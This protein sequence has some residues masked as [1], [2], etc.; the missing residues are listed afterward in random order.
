MESERDIELPSNMGLDALSSLLIAIVNSSDDAIISKTLDGIV[1]S[2]NPAAEAMFGY[3]AAEVVGQSIRIIIPSD[4]QEEEDFVL[5]KIRCGERVDHFETIRQTKDGQLLNISLTVS[6]VRNASGT[7]VGVSKI[8]RDITIRK[9]M[10]REREE[11]LARERQIRQQLADALAARDEFIAVAAHELRNPL[12][13]LNLSLQI[14]ERLARDPSAGDKIQRFILKCQNQLKQMASLTD[15]LL[16]VTK[17][18]TGT[19]EL[20]REPV[21]LGGL[22]REVA[23]RFA[24]DGSARPIS[25]QVPTRID[26]DFDRMRIDQA[27]TNL[28]SNAVRY[29][30]GKPIEVLATTSEREIAI[31][32]K[33]QGLGIPQT[34][35]KRIF[36]RFERGNK[37]AGGTGLGLGLWI[38]QRIA[39]A[40]GG[41]LRVESEVGKGST[42][43]LTLPL[44]SQ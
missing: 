5:G 14:L 16:D 23:S 19:F 43:T 21:D 13:V 4:R 34:D 26:G 1:T 20:M 15:R 8:A 37:R 39:E 9:R 3:T 31:A 42:F 29:G 41:I 36:E 7:V 17:I 11:L 24:S 22:I 33:D 27:L 28:L 32:V 12:N 2:W 30:A 38:T 40:H 44:R 25:L 10:E 6:P 35:L 18:R